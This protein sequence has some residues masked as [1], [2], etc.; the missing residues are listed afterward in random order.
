MISACSFGA[1]DA[2]AAAKRDAVARGHPLL[3][4][5]AATAPSAASSRSSA[6]SA[7]ASVMTS[8]GSSRTTVSAVRLTITPRA[9]APAGTTGAASRVSSRPQ[10]RPAPRTSLTIGCLA[11]IARSRCSKWRPTRADVRRAGRRRP[12]RRGSRAPRGRRA[13]CRRRCCRDRRTR[14]SRATSSLMSAAPIGTPPPSA[15]PSDDEVRLQADAPR[16]RTDSPVRPRPL[17]TSSAMS[18][19]PVLAARLVDRRGERRRQRP[20]AAFALNRL[21]DDRGRVRVDTAAGSA[22]GSLA[23]TKRTPGSSGSN[24]AR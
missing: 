16:S 1:C 6:S 21:D 13:G 9:R 17:C 11:A 23:G 24:G 3:L 15:L 14:S 19:A 20:H 7:S 5:P 8:G 22:A 18:S 10:I 12:A 2:S 4:R